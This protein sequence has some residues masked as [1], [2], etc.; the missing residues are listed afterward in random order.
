MELKV[1]RE[2]YF[3]RQ[4]NLIFFGKKIFLFSYGQEDIT[5]VQIRPTHSEPLFDKA[6]LH[7]LKYF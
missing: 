6:Y 2:I 3:G 4:K 7:V 5:V 1:K